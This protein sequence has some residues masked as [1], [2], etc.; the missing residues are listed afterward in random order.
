MYSATI[1]ALVAL[2]HRPDG[3]LLGFEAEAASTLLLRAD[4][5]IGD[6]LLQ[7]DAHGSAFKLLMRAVY[8]LA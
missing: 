4:P 1:G 2:G 8:H 3:L 7:D 5:I 6:V